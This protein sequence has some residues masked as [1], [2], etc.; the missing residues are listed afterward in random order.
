VLLDSRADLLA[1][2]EDVLQQRLVGGLVGWQFLA[3]MFAL[4]PWALGGVLR[5][6]YVCEL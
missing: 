1:L 2:L 3:A 5:V 4:S 6:S